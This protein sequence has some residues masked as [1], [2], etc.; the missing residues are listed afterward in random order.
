MLQLTLSKKHDNVHSFW[1]GSLLFLA[2]Q[3]KYADRAH[4][5]IKY[6]TFHLIKDSHFKVGNT[7]LS[8][9]KVCVAWAWQ[10]SCCQCHPARVALPGRRKVSTPPIARPRSCRPFY[11]EGCE[12]SLA[13]ASEAT[14]AGAR[15]ASRLLSAERAV[16]R[17]P[18]SPEREGTCTMTRRAAWPRGI[19]LGEGLTI[20][21]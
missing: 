4:S 9:M 18:R 12:W 1:T 11:E 14:A 2:G 17:V 21:P 15:S 16:P 19:L 13:A 20:I 10:V 8:T 3:R 5:E 7:A 6:F